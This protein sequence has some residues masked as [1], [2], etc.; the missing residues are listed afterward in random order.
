MTLHADHERLNKL[1]SSMR[2]AYGLLAEL[3]AIP[4]DKFL[5]DNHKISSAK[6]NFVAA[7]EAVIDISNHLISRNK[8]R[9]PQDYADTFSVLHEAGILE[10]KFAAELMKAARFRNRLVH[11]YWD[12]DPKELH[13]ILKTRLSDLDK[14]LVETGKH[15]RL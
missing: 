13:G 7:I 8:L 1:I 6:Y 12:V 10:K 9:A 2:T 4:D 11:L 5:K 15:I 14:F 3:A